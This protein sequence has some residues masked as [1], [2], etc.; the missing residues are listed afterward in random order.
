MI[1][2]RNI[3]ISDK[4]Y[5]FVEKLWLNSFPENERIDT[6]MQHHNIMY[7]PLFHCLVA[8]DTQP[9][10]FFTYWDFDTFCYCEHFAVDAAFRG[11]GHGAQIIHSVFHLLQ[12]PLILEV[13]MPND[14]ISLSRIKFYQRNGFQLWDTIPYAQPP[15]RQG[16]ESLPMLLMA[17]EGLCPER[18]SKRVIQRIHT[19]VYGF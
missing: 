9:I 19:D 5:P 7:N 12:R 4:V 3:S 1:H 17:T 10:G 8:E 11:Q 13:E 2:L 18:D 6:V 16:E 14:P 15:Y